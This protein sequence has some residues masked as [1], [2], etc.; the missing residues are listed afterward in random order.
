MSN[1]SEEY[2]DSLLCDDSVEGEQSKSPFRGP[3][4]HVL[5]LYFA[6]SRVESKIMPTALVY[7][8]GRTYIHRESNFT[9]NS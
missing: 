4:S 7:G 3:P 1:Q 5:V 6:F 9:K 8:Y 2:G